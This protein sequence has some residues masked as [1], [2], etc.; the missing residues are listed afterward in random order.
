MGVVLPMV[1][2]LRRGDGRTYPLAPSL[3]GRGMRLAAWERRD[4][5]EARLADTPSRWT[6][7]R[8]PRILLG[9]YAR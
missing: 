3:K 6:G 7:G 1:P 8:G 4:G 5:G 2:P 9:E